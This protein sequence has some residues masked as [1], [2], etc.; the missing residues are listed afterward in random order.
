MV[1]IHLFFKGSQLQRQS[2]EVLQKKCEY[3]ESYVLQWYETFRYSR[4]IIIGWINYDA[5]LL[6]FDISR[7]PFFFAKSLSKSS[8]I[9]MQHTV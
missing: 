1:S 7:R 8:S 6:K 2:I 3:V 4:G 5:F 9:C